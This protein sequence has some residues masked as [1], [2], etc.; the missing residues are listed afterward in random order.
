MKNLIRISMLIAVLFTVSCS[1]KQS[2][3]DEVVDGILNVYGEKALIEKIVDQKQIINVQDAQ[4]NKLKCFYYY[5]RPNKLKIDI[6]TMDGTSIIKTV[7][8]DKTGKH[9]I[10]N[11]SRD[12]TKEEIEEYQ[13]LVGSWIDRYSIY[14][15]E[16]FKYIKDIAEGADKFHVFEVTNQFGKKHKI[17]VNTKTGVVDMVDEVHIDVI[18]MQATNRKIVTKSYKKY[19]QISYP[20][21]VFVYTYNGNNN[22]NDKPMVMNLE[23]V[24]HNTG[25]D[26]SEFELN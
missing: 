11:E 9:I 3:I 23:K 12:M 6:K 26:D 8:N 20:E 15:K 1:P 18:S 21:K 4:G 17:Y 13:V 24:L 22:S 7:F 5:K 25:I 2:N 16:S 10:F 19:D 14:Q